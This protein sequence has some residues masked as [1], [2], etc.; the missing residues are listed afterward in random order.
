MIYPTE[1]LTV[2]SRA[3]LVT[4]YVGAAI[5]TQRA[6]TALSGTMPGR[7]NYGRHEAYHGALAEHAMRMLKLREVRDELLRLVEVT[8]A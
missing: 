3:R 2:G 8:A 1:G 7:P 4:G 5:A 6:L